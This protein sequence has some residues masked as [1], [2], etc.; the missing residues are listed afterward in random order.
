[1]S[2]NTYTTLVIFVLLV[3]ASAVSAKSTQTAKR[4]SATTE[5]ASKTT[6][7]P[8]HTPEWNNVRQGDPGR[9]AS[10]A[11]QTSGQLRFGDGK[12]GRIAGSKTKAGT[13]SLC[14]GSVDTEANAGQ[15]CA[16]LAAGKT[17]AGDILSCPPKCE[18][19]VG[20]DGTGG[21]YCP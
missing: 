2:R 10:P 20:E 17:C 4:E 18:E 1:M 13:V 19:N 6:P 7:A 16:K 9:A 21:C 5:Q 8:A 3:C 15:N 12:H 11:D 14:C